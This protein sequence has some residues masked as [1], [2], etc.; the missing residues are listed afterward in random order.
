MFPGMYS[1]IISFRSSWIGSLAVVLLLV[2]I[3]SS[4]RTSDKDPAKETGNLP[5]SESRYE[6]IHK[7][8]YENPSVARKE[9]LLILDTLDKSDLNAK[10]I[11]LKHLGSSF[12]FETNYPEAIKFYQQALS[13]AEEIELWSEVAHINNNLGVIYNEI[14]NYKTAYL[15]L[16]EALNNYEKSGISDK[17]IGALNNIGLIYLNLKNYEKAREFFNRALD[18]AIQPKDTILVVSVLNN[19]ALSYL[20]ETKHD[21]ALSHLHQAIDLSKQVNNKYGLC[22]SFQLMGNIYLQLDQTSKAY[23]AYQESIAIADSTNLTY[24]LASARLGIAGVL[25]KQGKT[26]EATGIAFQV[27]K[28]AEDQ[29]S[30]GLKSSV[31]QVLADIYEQSG[32]FS[33]SLHHYREHIKAQQEVVSQTIIHQVYDIELS[34]LDEVNK[35]QKLELEKKEL[36]ISKTNN[37]LFFISIT[38]ILLLIG[39]YLLYIN[40][41]HRQEVKFQKTVIELNAKKSTAALEAELQERKRIGQELHDSL[42]HL[43]SLSGLYTSMLEQRKDIAEEKKQELLE[44]L[45]RTIDEAFSEVRTI[46]HNLAPSLL[47]ERGLKGALKSISDRVNQ[48]TGLTM[49]FDTFGLNGKMNNLVEN[50]LFRTI[51]E[52]VNN[53]IKHASASRLFIQVTEGEN[54]ISLIAEDNGKGFNLNDV[55]EH[56]GSGLSHMKSR[57]ENLNGTI[58]IDSN[59]G[60]GTIISIL[61][62]YSN[63]YEQSYKSINS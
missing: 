25:L 35:T 2:L 59:P 8:I 39:L 21:L 41:R 22:I 27:M 55:D 53:T 49:S 38:F 63:D 10:I 14:G 13:I 60:R 9:V 57:I 19:I 31:H 36:A 37:L 30:L 45:K 42:G 15:Y 51:Q 6:Y 23:S 33:R 43:L 3:I 48:G 50:T 56:S 24:Q 61:I 58:D 4:C 47:S 62:P 52:I 11:L 28:E 44:S 16:T 5:G 12:V 40:R 7:L 17:K 20:N 26:T 18:P 29:K 32:D 34:H 1:H 46:S 54:E